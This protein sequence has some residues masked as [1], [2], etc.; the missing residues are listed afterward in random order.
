MSENDINKEWI[1]K[2]NKKKTKMLKVNRFNILCKLTQQYMCDM[3]SRL[4][5]FQLKFIEQKNN[6]LFGNNQ[7]IESITE[8]VF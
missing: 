2:T 8:S 6:Q 7:I 3:I 1:L 5:D 4:E